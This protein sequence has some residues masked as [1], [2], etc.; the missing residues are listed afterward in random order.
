MSW[1]AT[2]NGRGVRASVLAAMAVALAVVAHLAACGEL[3]S[4]PV[5]GCGLA[6]AFRV[7]W[8]CSGRQMSPRRIVGLVITVQ[9]GL[10]LAFAMTAR[11]AHSV[12]SHHHSA[13][14]VEGVTHRA[15]GI[16][17]LPGGPRMA[18]AHLCAAFLLSWWLSTGERLL[19]RVARRTAAVAR[20]AAVR[21]RR[22]LRPQTGCPLPARAVLR[23]RP[24]AG[25]A[26]ALAQLVHLVV[27]RGPPPLTPA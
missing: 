6:L 12:T 17:L 14:G 1:A 26:P 13:G 7:C 23:C 18:L 19:W 25:R 4:L 5:T 9:A 8:G 16:D 22:R 10:H 20:R 15:D 24:P 3:P 2:P 11:S 27:R 21:L